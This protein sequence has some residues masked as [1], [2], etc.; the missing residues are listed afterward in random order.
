MIVARGIVR[1][2]SLTR[3][4]TTHALSKPSSA[5]SVSVAAELTPDRLIGSVP[6]IVGGGATPVP[7]AQMPTSTAP[8]TGI[9]FSPSVSNCAPPARRTPARLTSVKN[10]MQ[11]IAI[12]AGAAPLSPSQGMRI[13]ML[14]IAATASVATTVQQ[15]IQ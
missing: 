11:P 15:L 4:L 3:S 13:D 10:Q 14:L 9:S 7:S 1:S 6:T 5:N 2:G 8:I 12:H